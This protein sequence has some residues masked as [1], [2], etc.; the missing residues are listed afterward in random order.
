M[1]QDQY[2]GPRGFTIAAWPNARGYW[3]SGVT[4]SQ[5][6]GWSI[7]RLGSDRTRPDYYGIAGVVFDSEG[8]E[9]RAT[10]TRAVPAQDLEVSFQRQPNGGDLH[11]EFGDVARTIS[12]HG[13]IGA[14]F[15][16]VHTDSPHEEVRLRASPGASVRL[17]AVVLEEEGG[18][19]VDNAALGGT[20]SRYH[21]ASLDPVYAAQVRRRDPHLVLLGFGGNEGNDFGTSIN[22]YG[23]NLRRM[24]SRV[25]RLTPNADC[26]LVGPLDK[27]LF[28]NGR[29]TH[30]YR[31][32][33]IARVQEDAAQE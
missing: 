12:T 17:Y 13:P 30:R 22:V 29:W 27:P 25:R 8:R 31:T 3:Q 23:T 32:T 11:I 7:V 16:V 18:V 19:V 14:G 20:K 1:L 33:S 10:L 28:R 21:L 6:E 9:A 2:G 15:E 26:V 5:G 24:L 4:I